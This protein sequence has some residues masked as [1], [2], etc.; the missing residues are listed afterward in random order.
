M[1]LCLEFEYSEKINPE[2]TLYSSRS[3]QDYPL[4]QII[5]VSYGIIIRD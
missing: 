5:P 1:V 2:C 3:N 4:A